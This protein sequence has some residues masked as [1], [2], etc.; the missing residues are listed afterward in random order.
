MTLVFEKRLISIVVNQFWQILALF[1]AF[2]GHLLAL[3]HQ[4]I[5]A[6]LKISIFSL[7]NV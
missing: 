1:W 4:N 7:L 3:F 2:F 5:L 6:T